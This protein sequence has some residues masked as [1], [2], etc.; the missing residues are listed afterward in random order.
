MIPG[1]LHLFFVLFTHLLHRPATGFMKLLRICIQ[2]IGLLCSG[3]VGVLTGVGILL[4]IGAAAASA[5]CICAA[6]KLAV[7]VFT[8]KYQVLSPY[9]NAAIANAEKLD[10]INDGKLPSASAPGTKVHVL[11]KKLKPYLIEV[12]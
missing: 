8:D 7:T 6:G 3:G 10:K 1:V 2:D 9:M 4:C 5:S 12:T 11:V